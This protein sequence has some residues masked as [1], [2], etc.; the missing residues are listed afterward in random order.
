LRGGNNSKSLLVIIY[1]LF[2]WLHA[3][4]QTAELSGTVTDSSLAA[5]VDATITA[6][7][8]NTHVERTTKGNRVGQ[9]AFAFLPPG[10][11]SVSVQAPGFKTARLE[12]VVLNVAALARLDFVLEVA[13]RNEIIT[14][15][16]A[17]LTVLGESAA[18]STAVDRHFVENLPLNGRTFQSLIALAP[19]VLPTPGDGQF[20]V[21][22]Q[23]DNAN[24]FTLDGVSANV[25]LSAFRALGQTAG[26]SVPGFNVI[27]AT[28]NL[29]S[30]DALEEF[31]VQTSSYS[32]EFGHTPGGQIQIVTRSGTAQFH[33]TAFDYFR[34]EVLDANDWFANAQS[35]KRAPLRLNDFGATFGGPILRDRTFFFMSYEGLRLRQPQFAA[36]N[37]PSLTARAQAPFAIAQLL[38]AFPQPNGPEDPLSMTA[39]LSTNYS[40]PTSVDAGSLRLDHTVNRKL[41]LFGR[42]SEARSRSEARADSLTHVIS[43][44]VNTRSVTFG[45][46][47]AATTAVSNEFRVNYTRNESSHFNRLDDFAGATPPPDSLLFPAPYASPRTSRFIFQVN[48]NG[49]RL[50]SGRSSDH[51]QRQLNF[52]NGLSVLKDSHDLKVGVDYRYLAP[53]F[54]PQDYGQQ[55]G[56]RTLRDAVSGLPPIVPIFV[57][58]ELTLS[59][60]NLGLYVQD[61]WRTTSR[62]TLSYGLRWEFNPP[63][64][65]RGNQSLYTLRG[66]SDLSTAQL[67][68][69]NTPLYQAT[70]ANFAPRVG[71]VY[72]LS[73]HAGREIVVRGGF[74]ISYDL[75]TGSIGDSTLSF[76]HFRQ[77]RVTG[78]SFPIGV[79]GAPP[80]IPGMDP[81]YA[82]QR[83]VLFDPAVRLPST[84]EWNVAWQRS[85]GASQTISATYVGAAGRQLLRRVVMAGSSPNFPDSAIDLTSNSATSDYHALQLQFQ[86]HLLHGLQAIASYCWSHSIDI[87]STDIEDSIPSRDVPAEQNRGSADFD[88]RHSASA[89]LIYEIRPWSDGFVGALFRHWSMGGILAA[90]SP[91]PVDITVIRSFGLDDI[92]AR[93]DVVPG[94]PFYVAD[95]NLAGGWR[96][97]R[98]AFVVPIEQR[99]G[100]LGRNLLRG[101]SLF[102]LDGSVARTVSVSDTLSIQLRADFFNV[103][104][105]PNFANP[106]GDLTS[107]SLFGVS[108][109]MANAPFNGVTNGLLPMFRVGG[110]RSVQL[111]L[112]FAF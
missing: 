10:T 97:N 40:D 104:N 42:F 57:F 36:I 1:L 39:Q 72:Q 28:S 86:R 20:S 110:P 18:V 51:L 66:F 16:A 21:N 82:G 77:K 101:F 38:K 90:R 106:S 74:G 34:N 80:P 92:A 112:K 103:L 91:T 100:T 52:V 63:P 5:L 76:P 58:D 61:S 96:I 19:G 88:I 14:V 6:T 27:G 17:S 48:D 107:D 37:V 99:Q 13:G 30:V 94:R 108:T 54:G 65:A 41:N 75:G 64:S 29:V 70:Y 93:P 67:A 24:Y 53:I 50:V 87:A 83:F 11:Y 105:H 55:I 60:H 4:A 84:Y 25:G 32:A 43:N 79:A 111:S 109:E 71:V 49:L 26:G 33:R 15:Q 8:Q 95:Q 69:A 81:P 56:Y 46:A 3:P 12:G 22:G 68:P 35:L 89:A 47:W 102:Q 44:A 85:I 59:F 98:D 2:V 7:N 73:D 78:V 23:R 62:L 45:T 9:Y 31:R